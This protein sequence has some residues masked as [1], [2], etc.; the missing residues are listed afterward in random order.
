MDTFTP[1]H[2]HPAPRP[3]LGAGPMLLILLA[4]LGLSACG[5]KEQAKPGQALASVNGS[6]I[7][8]LQLNEELQRAGAAGQQEAA[9][10]QLLE[11]L[12][13]RQLLTNEAAKEKLDRDPKVMQAIERAKALIIAQ[14]YIQKRIGGQAKPTRAEVEAYFQQ[15]PQFFG[16]RKQFDMRELVIA[17]KDLSDPLKAQMDGAKSLDEVAAWLDANKVKYAP[18]QLTRTS[19]DLPPELGAKLATMSKGQLFVIREGERSLL[20]QLSDIKD[21]PATLAASAPQIEQFLLNQKNKEAAEAEL[22]RLRTAAKI[23]Y[24]NKTDAV[25]SAD[26]NARGVAGL[27]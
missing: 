7:T 18:T 21:S 23:E 19:A 11:S 24:F 4:A 27:K 3:G 20:I 17:T 25:A 9:R 2:R 12:I 22:K 26:A 6:E 16:N 1:T 14:A 8:V 5:S 15:N 10:K 13:D